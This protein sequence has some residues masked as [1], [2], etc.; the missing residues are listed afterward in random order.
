MH[1]WT[2][3]RSFREKNKCNI[4][5]S[6]TWVNKL[7][8]R[9][10]TLSGNQESRFMELFRKMCQPLPRLLGS[11]P[12]GKMPCLIVISW[13]KWDRKPR[14]KKYLHVAWLLFQIF[15][16]PF[17]VFG[18]LLRW[19][20]TGPLYHTRG[21]NL[22]QQVKIPRC[23]SVSIRQRFLCNTENFPTSEQLSCEAGLFCH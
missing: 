1:S 23:I 15:Q 14:K 13:K 9:S 21:Q 3:T 18:E 16:I 11:I 12:N 5:L 4:Y 8:K 22:D 19:G 17:Q 20:R 6:V 7:N 2:K 10:L